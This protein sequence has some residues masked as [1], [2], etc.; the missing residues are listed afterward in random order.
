MPGHSGKLLSPVTTSDHSPWQRP[1]LGAPRADAADTALRRTR[2]PLASAAKPV[3]T[4]VSPWARPEDGKIREVRWTRPAPQP[5]DDDGKRAL[6]HPHTDLSDAQKIAVGS[7]L[8]LTIVLPFLL[9]PFKADLYAF[10]PGVFWLF[11]IFLASVLPLTAMWALAKKYGI[12]PG[13]Y[14]LPLPPKINIDLVGLSALVAVSIAVTYLPAHNLAWIYLSQY[15]ETRPFTWVDGLPDG[16]LRF[17]AILAVSFDAGFF[18]SV[19]FVGLPWLMFGNHCTTT[20]KK[21]SFAFVSAVI[22][23]ACHRGNGFPEVIAVTVFGLVAVLW[24][25]KLRNLWPVVIGHGLADVGFLI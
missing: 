11:K 20:A 13:Q 24:F 2:S 6:P 17:L 10:S 5:V 14:G 9:F 15:V 22:F 1:A 12:G 21:A 4:E 3:A 8:L 23:G 19:I 25:L 7:T 16:N 18:E